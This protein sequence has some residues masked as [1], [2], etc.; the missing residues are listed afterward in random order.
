M[1]KSF[2][3][4]EFF[5]KV[6]IHAFNGHSI[7][8]GQTASASD[9]IS[10][11]SGTSDNNKVV[12]LDSNGRIPA[13]FMRFGGDGSDGALNITSGTTTINLGGATIVEKNYTSINIS[14]TGALSFSNPNA[15]G[16]IVII[17]S[18]GDVTITSSAT[19]AIDLRNMGASSGNNPFGIMFGGSMAGG[20]GGSLG[21]GGAGGT[22]PTNPNLY[23]TSSTYFYSRYLLLLPGAGGGNGATGNSGSGGAGGA[24]GGALLIQCGGNLNFTGTI[25]SSAGNGT[26]GTGLSGRG[27]GGGGG[28]SAGMVVIL[29]D[30]ALTANT[31]TITATGGSGAHG[32]QGSS[33]TGSAGGGGGGAASIYATGGTGAGSNGGDVP[34]GAGNGVGA[35]GAGNTGGS[36]SV[37]GTPAAGGAS[38]GGLVAKNTFF[39]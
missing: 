30:G 14:G 4:S 31:G 38:M 9:F 37:G 18:M 19:A 7:A 1:D 16:T 36:G 13:G 15:S 2:I 28:G 27:S 17:K 29:Y 22:L 23:A 8:S 25:N 12:K 35:G 20:G 26:A 39:A 5:A 33:A 10:S 6:V 34:G 3:A 21:A 24:G 32:G 11:P